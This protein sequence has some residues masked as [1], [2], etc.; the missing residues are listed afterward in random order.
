MRGVGLFGTFNDT[1][2]CEFFVPT[3]DRKMTNVFWY[4]RD[5]KR[6]PPCL[7]RVAENRNIS[8]VFRYVLHEYVCVSQVI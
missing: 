1:I 3:C 7:V 4:A 2:E 6:I 8:D 5:G